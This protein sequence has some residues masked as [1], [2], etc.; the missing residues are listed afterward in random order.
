MATLPF[1]NLQQAAKQAKQKELPKKQHQ[2]YQE[3]VRLHID[4]FNY[5]VN[6]CLPLYIPD[7]RRERLVWNERSV[8]FFIHSVNIG[9]P[10]IGRASGLDR[11]LYPSECRERRV[12]YSADLQLRIGVMV[13][14][15]TIEWGFERMVGQVPIMV[16]SDRCYLKDMVPAELVRHHEEVEEMGGYFIINGNER[17]IR[18]LLMPRRNHITGLV[19]P[20]FRKRGSGYTQYGCQMRCVRRDE[21]AKTLT[22]HYLNNGTC[23][24][25]FSFRKAQYLLPAVM[26]LR[27]LADVSDKQIFEDIVHGAHKNSFIT[28][29]AKLMLRE[30]A[31]GLFTQSA[32]LRHLGRHF[33]VIFNMNEHG[34]SDRDMGLH[35]IEH[36]LFVHLEP[37]DLQA[38]YDCLILMIR[39]LLALVSGECAADSADSPANQ[40]LL[41]GAQV[42]GALLK[43]QLE[44][45]LLSVKKL[46][47]MDMRS[48][49]K[50]KDVTFS[51]RSYFGS[52]LTKA[53]D[54]G[55]KIEY[56]ITTGNLISPSGLDL[57]QVS[58]YTI[59]ADKLNFLRYMSH[60]RCVHRGA[61]FAEMKT[62][63][64]RKLLPESW[65]FMCP[66]HTPDGAPCGLLNHLAV[67]SEAATYSGPTDKLVQTLHNLGVAPVGTTGLSTHH[68]PVCVDGKVIG[69]LRDSETQ[70]VARDLRV[71]KVQC[72]DG[73]LARTLEIG[74][75]PTMD[76]GQFPGL[77]LFTTPTRMVRPVRNLLLNTT[78]YIGSFEQV[79]MEIACL[80]EDF[81]EGVTT[82]MEERP[83]NMLSIVANFTPFSDFNQ[84]PRNMYQCQMGKQTM[85]F[86]LHSYP[87]R[88]DNKLY[89][90]H[91]PQTPLVRPKAYDEYQMDNYPT[92]TNAIVAVISYT[93]YD[94]EDA[95]ILNKGSHERGFTHAHVVATKVIDLV[96]LREKAN[97]LSHR[98]GAIKGDRMS[99]GLEEDGFP[100]VGTVLRN[101]DPYCG[102]I[103]Q[104]TG[105]MSTEKHKGDDPAVVLQVTLLGGDTPSEAQ[106]ATVKLSINRNPIIG[107]KFASRHGQ[108]GILSQIWPHE[109][110]PF[111]ES[112]MVPDI[113][114]NPHGFPSRMTIGMLIES[115]AGKGAALHSVVHDATAFQFSEDQTAIEYFGKQLVAAGYNY[116]GNE[117]L[118]SGITGQEFEADI[119]MG[120]VYY[121][122]LRHMVSDK[123]QVRTTGPVNS[124]TLQPIKGRKRNGG[125]RFGEMERD[126][127]LAHGVAFLLQDRLLHN[128]DESQTLV[129]KTCGSLLSPVL[130]KPSEITK[131]RKPSCVLCGADGVIVTLSLPHV[132]KLLTTEL[133]GMGIRMTLAVQEA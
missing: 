32:C 112:G 39:K 78:E 41:V 25:G 97:V 103:N 120:M 96:D 94:M 17:I 82:H 61:F 80:P 8:E 31:Q 91:T 114:F 48:D 105:K 98:F 9:Q 129:C 65:G 127:L 88:A 60:F 63:A 37:R 75:V 101:G 13:E 38:K 113:I 1:N 117:R 36:V 11:T 23:T 110:M 79:Y 124:M 81:K 86:P 66:V 77:Y 123:Y 51:D 19:R 70:R 92:G 100:A 24:L 125:I 27:A 115:M 5:M 132:F 111:S 56:M 109:N 26:V 87:N 122:R 131:I 22:L 46:I 14:G 106:R 34:L 99:A 69:W 12:T 33:R 118:Y 84:S 58:G 90:L 104:I 52:V 2:A 121:Q 49:K 130:E 108:K 102:Y 83:I 43:E 10:S 50:S 67:H 44:E 30:Q 71:L 93:G 28:E 4:A 15:E 29:R 40:E 126:S 76:R 20:S 7:L 45:Y 68:V 62:T 128:S 55:K 95:M 47:Q 89:C 73:S 74:L 107:D 59:M 133:L 6:E 42:Y 119:F 54:I 35:M 16:K 64:V 53:P 18:T 3:A 21:T 85:G 57:M 72:K 116:Y